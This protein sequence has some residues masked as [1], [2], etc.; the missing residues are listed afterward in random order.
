[1]AGNS[2]PATPGN[3]SAADRP[4]NLPPSH[5]HRSSLT[6]P[7]AATASALPRRHSESQADPHLPDDRVG[8]L[9]CVD[10]ARPNRFLQ[11]RI[12]AGQ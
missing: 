7:P 10:H 2:A 4:N 3:G 5:S 9:R 12:L 6:C 8:A 1:M 11:R